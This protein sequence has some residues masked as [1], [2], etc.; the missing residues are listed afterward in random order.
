M[1]GEQMA[2]GSGRTALGQYH[3]QQRDKRYEAKV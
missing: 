2:L 1:S 3:I